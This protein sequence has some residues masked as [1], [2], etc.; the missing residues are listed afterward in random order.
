MAQLKKRSSVNRLGCLFHDRIGLKDLQEVNVGQMDE[1][2]TVAVIEK[3]NLDVLKAYLQWNVINTASSYLV[4]TLL[5]RTLIFM[6]ELFP[7]QKEIVT[8]D[9]NVPLAL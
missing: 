2:K 7:E 8:L 3:K 4:I 9:G 5:H 1:V 6:E